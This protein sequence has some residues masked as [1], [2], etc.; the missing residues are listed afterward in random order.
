MDLPGQ[1]G[2]EQKDQV[3]GEGVNDEGAEHRAPD[4]A[5]AAEEAHDDQVEGD[6]EL[7]SQVR[8]DV[9]EVLGVQGAGGAREPDTDRKGQDLV[10]GRIDARG[11]GLALVLTDRDQAQA[12][13]RPPDRDRD[14]DGDHQQRQHGVIEGNDDQVCR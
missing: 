6:D 13:F 11:F 7:E 14:Q 9:V 8:V 1:S 5:A 12:E 2:G 10:E 4:D 3:G